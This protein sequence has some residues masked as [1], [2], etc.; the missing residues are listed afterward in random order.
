MKSQDA[1]G[2]NLKNWQTMGFK[3][4]KYALFQYRKEWIKMGRK[5]GPSVT[6][7]K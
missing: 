2:I 5:I 7:R 6:K 4:V 3:A 1:L